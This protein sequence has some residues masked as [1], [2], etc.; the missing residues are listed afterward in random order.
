MRSPGRAI[1][2]LGAAVALGLGDRAIL[3]SQ[4][5]RARKVVVRVNVGG[6][7]L[8]FVLAGA[9]LPRGIGDALRGLILSE[10]SGC[11]EREAAEKCRKRDGDFEWT[12][13]SPR[14][15]ALRLERRSAVE[16]S[17][18]NGKPTTGG[19]RVRKI[20]PEGLAERKSFSPMVSCKQT[21]QE[22]DF[23]RPGCGVWRTISA[24]SKW[25]RG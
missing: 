5:V 3:R 6:R 15:Q 9:C 7:I 2:F 1:L 18:H 22:T 24:I 17:Q 4:D 14:A 13:D 16:G 8:F 23:M 19:L 25:E 12:R 11:T 10:R 21:A 20:V